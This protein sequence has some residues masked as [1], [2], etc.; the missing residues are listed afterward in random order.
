MFERLIFFF[1]DGPIKA[2]IFFWWKFAIL[3][4]KKSPN[5]GKGTFWKFPQKA[6]TLWKKKLWN[7]QFFGGFWDISTIF[8]ITMFNWL[9]LPSSSL[10]I[11]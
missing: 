6:R 1:C 4:L 5:M 2:M 3:L 9:K 11:F 8:E 7:R 10:A